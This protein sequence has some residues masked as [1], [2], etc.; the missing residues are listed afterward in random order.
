MTKDDLNRNSAGEPSSPA[1]LPRWVQ[2]HLGRQLRATLVVDAQD[3]PAYLGDPTLPSAFD[4]YLYEVAVNH[5][6]RECRRASDHG[7]AAVAAALASFSPSV[8]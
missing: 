8:N 7:L 1:A 3:K 4:Q 5:R 6:T 2:E